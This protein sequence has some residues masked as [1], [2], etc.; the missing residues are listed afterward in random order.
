MGAEKPSRG[1]R[2]GFMS[3]IDFGRPT[4]RK[5]LVR[6]AY[7]VFER[8]R[9]L[10]IVL[11]G[12][13]VSYRHLRPHI[14]SKKEAREAVFQKWARELSADIP[15]LR[16]SQ[17]KSVKLYIVPS[18][19]VDY[20]GWLGVEIGKRLAKLR[21]HDIRL[22][23]AEDARIELQK[24]G[25]DFANNQYFGV[26]LPS[27]AAWSSQYYSTTAERLIREKETQSTQK[28]PAW[29][30]SD[31][32]ASSILRPASQKQRSY[33]TPP[34]LHRLQEVRTHENQIGCKVAE[35][36][37][38]ESLLV[39]TYNFKDIVSEERYKVPVPQDAND[40]QRR[41]LDELKRGPR[42][43]GMLEDA[44]R[45]SRTKII[46]EIGALNG[47][48]YQPRIV[49][50]EASQ[51]YDL[52]QEWFQKEL[53]YEM[54][55]LDDLKEDTLVGFGCL[56]AGSPYSEYEFFVNKVPELILNRGATILVGAGDFIQGL[57]HDL[58][59]SGEVIGGF[60][61]SQQEKFAAHLVGAAILKVF[62]PRF[63]DA[64]ASSSAAVS[65]LSKEALAAMVDEALLWFDYR[66]GNHDTWVERKGIEPLATFRS[67]LVN[68]LVA[69]LEEILS[70]RD[71]YVAGLRKLVEQHTTYAETHA[72]P[73]GVRM[74]LFHPYM[75]RAQTSSLRAQQM[76]GASDC[77]VVVGANF[78]EAIAVE[79]WEQRLGQR[80]ALQ[81]ST[82][83]WQTTFETRKLK[84]LEVCVGYLRILSKDGRIFMSETGFYGDGVRHPDRSNEQILEQLCQELG[85]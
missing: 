29:W 61:Y 77:Q 13:L 49:Y 56:H 17:G 60:N 5:G 26:L 50:D 33:F 71:L 59:R 46:D 32:S 75:A 44:L 40:L 68:Y 79:Q 9:T 74:E 39:R 72:L 27:K 8:E 55:S 37:H 41:I 6:L 52:S 30:A 19:A 22:W 12:G 76:L 11:A 24:N 7:E 78:H 66:S 65:E 48:G 85:I 38:D 21:R 62:L 14:P 67:E 3:R 10:F 80:V 51:R 47:S 42:T 45:T 31:C 73:S 43:P 84:R 16:D 53:R 35:Y 34:A 81:V 1:I 54:P 25:V 2:I 58:D 36:F 15:H 28:H 57:E 63:Q 82:I 83:L 23:D 70:A 64:V 20:D 69:G 4:Y 18:P